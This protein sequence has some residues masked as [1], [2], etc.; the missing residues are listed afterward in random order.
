MSSISIFLSTSTKASTVTRAQSSPRV[1][2]SQKHH[3]HVHLDHMQSDHTKNAHDHGTIL[4]HAAVKEG[5]SK[6]VRKLLNA[7]ENLEQANSQ[8]QTALHLASQKGHVELVNLLL[9]R[10]ADIYAVDSFS[11]TPLHYAALGGHVAIAR[12]LLEK[13]REISVDHNYL[14]M[15]NKYGQTV[16]NLVAEKGHTA[17]LSFLIENNAD[18]NSTEN[19]HFTLLHHVVKKNNLDAVTLLIKNGVRLDEQE[20]IL[21]NTPL[22]DAVKLGKPYT[23]VKELLDA[24]ARKDLRNKDG[25]TALH[26]AALYSDIDCVQLFFDKESSKGKTSPQKALQALPPK[27]ISSASIVGIDIENNVGQT[28]LHC[29]LENGNDS[30]VTCLIDAGAGLDEQDNE[31]NSPLH[32]AVR[33]NMFAMVSYLLKKGATHDICNGQRQT[34][35]HTAAQNGSAGVLL[36]DPLCAKLITMQD[37]DGLTPLHTAL[38][39]NQDIDSIKKLVFFQGADLSLC[40]TAGRS[41]LHYAVQKSNLEAV[42]WIIKAF[43]EV[44]TPD[45][46]GYTPLLDAFRHSSFDICLFLVAK[47][48]DICAKTNNQESILHVVAYNTDPQVVKYCVELWKENNLDF[49]LLDKLGR[50]PL[51]MAVRCSNKPLFDELLKQGLSLEKATPRGTSLF[52]IAAGSE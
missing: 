28:A 16:I 39:T 36:E 10:G 26:Y 45:N 51:E 17:L 5:K 32:Y 52:M 25:M 12:K 18:V 4:L 21:G 33:L 2:S 50:S 37:E 38:F 41:V 7:G 22:H 35:L 20:N 15:R 42:C 19:D 44:D 49:E 11:S 30:I 46:E 1:S 14:E 13:N 27:S 43:A 6:T 40:D 29:A 23:L 31:G 47:S 8:G 34:I 3:T 24:G 48:A 9:A